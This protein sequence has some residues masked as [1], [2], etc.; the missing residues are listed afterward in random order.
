MARIPASVIVS[1]YN[2]RSRL[3]A[4]LIGLFNQTVSP[5]EIIVVDDHS[6]DGTTDMLEGFAD[7]P[8][9]RVIPLDRH[10]GRCLARNRGMEEAQGELVLFLDG[11]ALPGP[12][13]LQSFWEAHA[14][15]KQDGYFVGYKY[16]IKNLEFI[17]DLQK[18]TCFDYTPSFIPHIVRLNLEE[19]AITGEM[20]AHNFQKI[21]A[22]AQEGGYPYPELA[23]TQRQIIELLDTFPDSPI[24]WISASPHSLAVPAKALARIKGFDGQMPH[25]EAWKFGLDLQRVGFRPHLVEEATTYHL[26]H[27]HRPTNEDES[28]RY[29]AIRHMM[30]KAGDSR[31]L[32]VQFWL[33]TVWPDRF[34]P[35]EMR[36][37]DLVAL[38]RLYTG[39]TDEAFRPYEHV[40]NRHPLWSRYEDR[41]RRS[42]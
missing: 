42:L 29:R 28:V 24:A 32:L 23:K 7:T 15:T 34:I 20:V 38:H 26:Y 39:L 19:Y 33:G 25:S 5:G 40:F 10:V 3:R 14:R 37:P 1:S 27:H 18:G 2:Q 6:S 12:C 41:Y 11:D 30:H 35:E 9:L 31:I 36:I 13:W 17:E 16:S 4:V 8:F 22:R 21:Q